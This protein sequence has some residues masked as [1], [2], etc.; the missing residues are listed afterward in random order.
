MRP[1]WV[2]GALS[3]QFLLFSLSAYS[4][5][6]V[7]ASW[8]QY[9]ALGIGLQLAIRVFAPAAMRTVSLIGLWRN[10]RWGWIVAL[11]ANVAL[12]AQVLW[13]LL[14]YAAWTIRNPRWL[15]LDVLD[16][17]ALVVLLYKPVWDHFLGQNRISPRAIPPVGVQGGT[18]QTVQSLRILVYFAVTVVATCFV[19]AFSLALFMGQKNGG[20][21][22]FVLILYFGFVT[23]SVASFLFTLVLTLLVRKLGPARRWLWL[24]LGA[25]LAPALIF[26]FSF[27]AKTSPAA[28]S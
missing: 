16:F 7:L 24:L 18:Y 6:R 15:A 13:F 28:A 25:S 1:A 4:C 17:A 14:D 5:V 9:A 26:V 23:G 11:I 27:V 3:L 10:R 2:W 8:S 12:C 19:A 21:R 22:A 20:S